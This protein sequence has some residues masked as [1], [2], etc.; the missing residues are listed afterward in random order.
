MGRSCQK[1]D[2]VDIHVVGDYS[3]AW[4]GHGE[5]GAGGGGAGNQGVVGIWFGDRARECTGGR[6][7][8]GAIDA[9]VSQHP[10]IAS[11][12]VSRQAQFAV[13]DRECCGTGGW[14]IHHHIV[15]LARS[16]KYFTLHT[17]NTRQGVAIL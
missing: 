5:R 11:D 9:D 3:L 8:T 15:S 2:T 13:V 16:H 6:R 12:T 17:L 14:H 10:T 1:P 4:I 7:E